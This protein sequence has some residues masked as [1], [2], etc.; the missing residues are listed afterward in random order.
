MFVRSDRKHFL[1]FLE[2]PCVAVRGS[3]IRASTPAL[4]PTHLHG[5]AMPTLSRALALLLFACSEP[6]A[7]HWG[8]GAVA[9]HR[10]W[11][12]VEGIV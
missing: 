7:P 12:T 10:L 4:H 5:S 11:P 8:P 1:S 2:T 6:A 3:R 9:P